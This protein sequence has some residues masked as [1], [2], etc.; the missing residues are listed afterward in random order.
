VG[1]HSPSDRLVLRGRLEER[2]L[3]AFWLG[4]D[5]HITAGVH[6]NDWD[7]IE[8][9]KQLVA[10]GLAVDAERLADEAEPRQGGFAPPGDD[11]A[12]LAPRKMRPRAHASSVA[13]GAVL[14]AR[15]CTRDPIESETG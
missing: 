5:G 2:R 7:S 10:N 1:L 15:R 4:E 9:I 12:G 3:Q 13:A 11:D 8:P 14:A 6:V